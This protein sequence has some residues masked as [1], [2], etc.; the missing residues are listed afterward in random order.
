VSGAEKIHAP[1]DADEATI[2]RPALAMLHRLGGDELVGEIIG[3]FLANTPALIEAA[4]LGAE[5]GEHERVRRA[6][7]SLKSSSGQL[8]AVRME[9]LC[10]EGEMLAAHGDR[11]VLTSLVNELEVEFA[12]VR[13]RMEEI[14]RS[15]LSQSL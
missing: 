1:I 15:N 8:G 4:R 2:H 9:R 12:V 10:A 5:A 13:V 3:V 6:L 11:M 7:H 14:V